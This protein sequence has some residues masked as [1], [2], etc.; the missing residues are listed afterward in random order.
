MGVLERCRCPESQA[1]QGR[2]DW[3]PLA[4]H[5]FGNP[6]GVQLVSRGGDLWCQR[7]PVVEA[8]ADVFAGLMQG[9]AEAGGC[10]CGWSNVAETFC[11][12]TLNFCFISEKENRLDR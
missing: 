8:G 12:L 3:D 10:R 2:L 7:K 9:C 6:L 11:K 1:E 4:D 5:L